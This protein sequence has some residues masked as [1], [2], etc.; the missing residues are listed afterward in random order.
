MFLRRPA[1]TRGAAVFVPP[2]PSGAGWPSA[3]YW[4]IN[5]FVFNNT[6]PQIYNIAFQDGGTD[7]VPS[8]ITTAAGNQTTALTNGSITPDIDTWSY[9]DFDFG[10]A[11]DA[12]LL[13]IRFFEH[14]RD[15]I[16]SADIYVSD[17]DITYTQIGSFRTLD[18][19][20]QGGMTDGQ[21][22]YFDIGVEEG[23]SNQLTT[24]AIAG[25]RDDGPAVKQLDTYGVTG[26]YDKGVAVQAF[27]TYVVTKPI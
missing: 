4:R 8:S 24:Y 10:V 27:D 7:L 3:R 23:V 18:S 13:R 25:A 21:T 19:W 20:S 11:V 26:G 16:E 22:L 17:D 14:D 12:D 2:A 1:Y 9:F 6:I 5:N 15:F